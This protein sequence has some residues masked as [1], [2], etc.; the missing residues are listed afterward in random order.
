MAT[1]LVRPVLEGL[2]QTLR[3]KAEGYE[4]KIVNPAKV[5]GWDKNYSYR[6]EKEGSHEVHFSHSALSQM[7]NRLRIPVT[8]YRRNPYEIQNTLFNHWR[9]FHKTAGGNKKNVM[10]RFNHAVEP[11]HVRAVLSDVYGKM[12]DLD[13]FK[14]LLEVMD[15]RQDISY[16]LLEYDAH[17]TQLFIDFNDCQGVHNG[18]TYTAGL[19]VT[20]SETGHSAVWIEPVVHALH[21][22]YFN[23][24]TLRQQGVDCRIVHRGKLAQKRVQPMVEKAK[25]IA[26]VGIT[27][28]AE[29]FQSRFSRDAAIRMAQNMEAL[30]SRFVQ[31]LEEEWSQEEDLIRAEA[32]R[33]ILLLAQELPLFQRIQIQQ[34]TGKMLGLFTNYKDRFSD[35]ASEINDESDRARDAS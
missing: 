25:E 33:R 10:F 7:L 8:F 13:L 23:R 2:H 22:S 15:E 31:L 32:A 9:N 29:S 27:Q 30:P 21:C 18:T 3:A 20:N 1:Q 17:I 19:C 5:I 26:Q 16:R 6:N 4:D 34:D 35:L 14:V 11:N 12:D 28:L 24:R